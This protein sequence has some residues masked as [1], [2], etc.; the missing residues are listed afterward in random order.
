MYINLR[1]FT[2]ELHRYDPVVFGDCGLLNIS[3]PYHRR[4][5]FALGLTLFNRWQLSL[6]RLAPET[7]WKELFRKD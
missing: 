1:Y 3:S 2:L 4:N 7:H 6:D 5:F